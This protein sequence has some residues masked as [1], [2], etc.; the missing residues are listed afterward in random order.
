MSQ[1]SLN[2]SALMGLQIFGD[3]INPHISLLTTA[4][5]KVPKNNDK[6]HGVFITTYTKAEGTKV[7]K[8]EYIRFLTFGCAVASSVLIQSG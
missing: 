4:Q 8:D 7:L 5:Y 1:K 3:E 2:I 6:I